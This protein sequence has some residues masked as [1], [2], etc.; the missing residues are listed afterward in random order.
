MIF[1]SSPVDASSPIRRFEPFWSTRKLTGFVSVV[2]YRH[3]YTV[4]TVGPGRRLSGVAPA[5]S[6]AITGKPTSWA[7]D[8]QRFTV[9][10]NLRP[11]GRFQA[12]RKAL[13]GLGRFELPTHGLGNRCS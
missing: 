2:Y 3:S 1:E 7:E 4:A 5:F 6:K 10:E 12:S 13:V 8:A 9:R 11:A